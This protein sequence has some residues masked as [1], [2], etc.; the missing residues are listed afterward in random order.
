MNTLSLQSTPPPPNSLASLP[1][2]KGTSTSAHLRAIN[3][4]DIWFKIDCF[5]GTF[6]FFFDKNNKAICQKP[7][8]G[9]VI[10]TG[11]ILKR[12]PPPFQ[13]TC[14]KGACLFSGG[15]FYTSLDSLPNPYLFMTGA[16]DRPLLNRLYGKWAPWLLCHVFY[17]FCFQHKVNPRSSN[18]GGDLILPGL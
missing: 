17:D 6:F 16:A 12:S 15:S 18:G 11:F 3:H 10:S 5:Q 4:F 2:F 7:S 9:H 8:S 1:L 14:F 13:G